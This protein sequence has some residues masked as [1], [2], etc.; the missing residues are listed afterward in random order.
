MNTKNI[1]KSIFLFVLV[2]SLIKTDYRLVSEINCCSDDFEY[3]IHSQTIVEDRDFDYSNQIIDSS[4][5]R[6]RN[7]D[8]IA[9]AGFVGSG[10]MASPFYFLGYILNGLFEGSPTFNFIILFYSLSSIFYLFLS[11]Y[12]LIKSI[13]LINPKA[14]RFFLTLI[15]FGSGI[16]YY[17]FERYSMTHVYEVFITSFHINPLILGLS[18]VM[19]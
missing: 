16:S 15:F 3:F 8:K 18:L 11:L 19:V 17:A 14:N 6:F 1:I 10:I 12:L 13:E 9:P 5:A 4:K 7:G 2:M